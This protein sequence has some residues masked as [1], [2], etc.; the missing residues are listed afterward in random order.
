[1]KT[2]DS[3]QKPKLKGR[4]GPTDNTTEE[5]RS[6]VSGH[7]HLEDLNLCTRTAATLLQAEATTWNTRPALL[8]CPIF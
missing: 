1:M 2:A 8:D 5:A 4:E 6:G 3:E 7:G